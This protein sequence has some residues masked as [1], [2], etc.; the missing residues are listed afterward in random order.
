MRSLLS[1]KDWKHI[2]KWVRKENPTVYEALLDAVRRVRASFRVAETPRMA[3]KDYSKMEP[4][5]V[6]N[7][8]ILR[9]LSSTTLTAPQSKVLL[10]WVKL[11]IALHR[12][13]LG[14]IDLSGL[15]G[16]TKTYV[17]ET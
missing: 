7:K 16:A 3:R 1:E 4:K 10:E 12:D 17:E 5:E 13:T 6:L 11:Y 8:K 2:R 15:Q 9:V 14:Y